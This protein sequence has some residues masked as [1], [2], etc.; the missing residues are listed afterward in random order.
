M[1]EGIRRGFIIKEWAF[2]LDH[3]GY[4]GFHRQKI[5]RKAIPDGTIWANAW[6]CEWAWHAGRPMRYQKWNHG[7]LTDG[8]PV[9]F[10]WTSKK[11]CFWFVFSCSI[12]ILFYHVFLQVTIFTQQCVRDLFILTQY[13][14]NFKLW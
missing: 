13:L 11:H 12:Q 14:E 1:R 3:Q 8:P 4:V 6:D 2:E 10:I 9:L 5:K 7:G